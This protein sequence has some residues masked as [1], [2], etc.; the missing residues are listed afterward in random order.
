V[1]GSRA[2]QGRGRRTPR[3]SPP[4]QASPERTA[5]WLGIPPRY[6]AETLDTYTATTPEQNIALGVA[7]KFVANWPAMLR[8]GRSLIFTGG[9]GTGKTHLAC[10]IGSAV[11]EQHLAVPVF[12]PVTALL[13]HIKSTYGKNSDRTEKQAMA[14][15]VDL[16]D[17]LIVD[18]IGTS[19]GT[20]HEK[21]LLFEVLNERYQRL[22]PTILISNLSVAE[23]QD[24][25]GA[26][27]MDRYRQCGSVIA[28]TWNSYRGAAAA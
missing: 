26:R 4:A 18:E 6:A 25:L 8:A 27:A 17:L 24:Y 12:M 21:T 13:R 28:F 11:A 19:H 14:D 20:D 3:R 2:R 7:R 16:P 15:L 1:R 22:R 5:R 10:A 9:T 23:L